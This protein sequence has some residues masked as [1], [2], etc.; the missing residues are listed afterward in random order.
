[1]I[2]IQNNALQSIGSQCFRIEQAVI[3]LLDIEAITEK[4]IEIRLYNVICIVFQGLPGPKGQQG[5]TGPPGAPVS[6][7]F[8]L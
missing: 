1:M 2:Y 3:G 7:H 6:L 4:S 8:L 5:S